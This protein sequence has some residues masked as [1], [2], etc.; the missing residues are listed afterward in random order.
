MNLERNILFTFSQA[1]C[2]KEK[3]EKHNI[4]EPRAVTY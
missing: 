3:K 2:K 4:N 1:F